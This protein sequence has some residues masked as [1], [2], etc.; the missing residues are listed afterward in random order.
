M[1]NIENYSSLHYHMEIINDLSEGGY[2]ASYPDL[3]GCLTC[4]DTL[5]EVVKNADEAKREWLL[6]AMEEGI[7]IPEPSY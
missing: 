1:T 2:V 4:G 3:P 6:A 7:D 5:E